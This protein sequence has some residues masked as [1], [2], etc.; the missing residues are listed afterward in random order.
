MIVDEEAWS[1]ESLSIRFG[2]LGLRRAVDVSLQ[3]LVSSVH[4]SSSLV[5]AIT[6]RVFG[7]AATTEI[8]EAR[9]LRDELSGETSA[10]Q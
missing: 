8:V 3:A 4:A 9:T 2:G 10:Q 1:Q 6:S 7:L 5:D